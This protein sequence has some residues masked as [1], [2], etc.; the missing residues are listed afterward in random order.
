[1]I[2]DIFVWFLLIT[3]FAL[4][5]IATLAFVNILRGIP[6]DDDKREKAFLGVLLFWSVGG[7]FIFLA[8]LAS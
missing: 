3:A 6:K 5:G 2:K 7:L 8:H 1:M 4:L